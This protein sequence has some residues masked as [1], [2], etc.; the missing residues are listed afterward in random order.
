MSDKD[1]IVYD[2]DEN[3]ATFNFTMKSGKTVTVVV[4]GY[5]DEVQMLAVLHRLG[6]PEFLL[7]TAQRIDSLYD[8]DDD[9]V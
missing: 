5:E 6:S 7:D 3:T 8:E 9:D 2:A 4:S 1:E